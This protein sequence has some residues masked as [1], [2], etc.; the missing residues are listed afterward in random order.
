MIDLYLDG[1]GGMAKL[2]IVRGW[3][4]IACQW[5]LHDRCSKE[6]WDDDTQRLE[7]CQCEVCNPDEPEENE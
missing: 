4:C 5:Q 1:G 7:L 6:L 2:R 3:T